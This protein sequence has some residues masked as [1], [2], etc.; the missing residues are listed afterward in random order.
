[1]IQW[2]GWGDLA[3]GFLL[4]WTMGILA[5]VGDGSGHLW[6]S[7]DDPKDLQGQALALRI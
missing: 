3:Q 5:S 6:Y 2:S 4:M 7:F 1:M